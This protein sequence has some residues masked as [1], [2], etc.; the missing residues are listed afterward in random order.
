MRQPSEPPGQSWQDDVVLPLLDRAVLERLLEELDDDD[1]LWK[2]FVS[3]FIAYAPTR[4]ERLRQA[5]TTG[6]LT[7]SLDAVLSLKTS[8]Q[9]VGAE[10]LAGLALNLEQT[11]WAEPEMDADRV[12]PWL[13]VTHLQPIERC[14]R[15]TI[16]QLYKY[17]G[18][19]S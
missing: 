12:L 18:R 1:S 4:I 9:M 10:R 7:G 17:M 6:D 8:S 13:A 15:Q 3:N 2:I 16:G 11:L 14:S 5:L 19:K